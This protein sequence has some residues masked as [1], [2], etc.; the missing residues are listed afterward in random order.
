MSMPASESELASRRWTAAEVRALNESSVTTRYECVDGALLVTPAPSLDHQEA[1]GRLY[2]ALTL[3]LDRERVGHAFVAPADVELDSG[4]L[5]QPD[6]FVAP[7]REGDRPRGRDRIDALL[8][9][10]EVLS[11]STA[12]VDRLKKRRHHQRAGTPE[13]W[14]VDPEIRAIERTRPGAAGVELLDTTLAWRPEGAATPFVL[15]VEAY[16]AALL[17]T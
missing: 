16:F 4:T 7:L 5:M 13:Y 9:A 3:Y 6:V 11:P 12:R 15:D 14:V 1:V 17:D 2:I 8:L 10:V